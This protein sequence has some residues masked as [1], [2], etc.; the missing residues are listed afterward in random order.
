MASPSEWVD[1]R[2]LRIP[3]LPGV[4]ARLQSML[5]DPE[6]GLAEIGAVIATDPPLAAR[7][8]RTANSAV[9]GLREPVQTIQRAASV[10][11]VAS[12]RNIV[13]QVC[14][15]DAFR[16]LAD[17]DRSNLE[18]LWRHSIACALTAQEL[19]FRARTR[20]VEP[21]DA[22]TCALLH[23]LGKLIL[24]EASRES[25]ARIVLAAGGQGVSTHELEQER[26]GIS[27]T[28]VG[29]AL[30]REWSLPD[31]IVQ[32]IRL[33]HAP[34]RELLLAPMAA[35][36]AMGDAV[37][38]AVEAGVD[39]PPADEHAASSLLDIDQESLQEV[40]EQTRGVWDRIEM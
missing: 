30:A 4:V 40:V 23:D 24:F 29:A 39:P 26:L 6:T 7:I 37:V 11:G 31:E 27:H 12:L 19:G 20:L 38:L 21:Y 25:Y 14:L 5:A 15:L 36:V 16:H 34:R 2:T 1:V 33:H 3:S 32:S 9:F 18:R 28:E 13:L 8:L 10:L 22:Y 17:D 35:L